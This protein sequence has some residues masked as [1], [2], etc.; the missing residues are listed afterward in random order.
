[1]VNNFSKHLIRKFSQVIQNKKTIVKLIILLTMLAFLMTGITIFG[2]RGGTRNLGWS[3]LAITEDTMFLG[4]TQG[5]MLALSIPGGNSIWE[6]T[7]ETEETTGGLFGCAAAAA[8]TPLYGTPIVDDDILYLGAYNGK[9][10]AFRVGKDDP[11][12]IFPR[13]GELANIVGGPVLFEG[14]IYIG[15]SDGYLY[16]LDAAEGYEEWKFLTGN[17][18]WA[19]P[20][21]VN[22][23]LYVGSFDHKLYAININ[24]HDVIWAP[25]ETEGAIVATPTVN[26]E[27]VYFGSFDRRIYALDITTGTLKWKSSLA[28]KWF[29]AQAIVTEEAVYAA[30][31]DGKVYVLDSE[32]GNDLVEAI[33]L[34]D[35]ISSSPVMIDD[36]IIIATESGTIWSIN[37]A[38]KQ[39]KLL[40]DLEEKI[41][42][43][44]AESNGIIYIHSQD[45]EWLYALNPRSGE[46][47]WSIPLTNED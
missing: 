15:V 24:T 35:P 13:Q 23:I 38:T 34:G 26:D 45:E 7:L 6:V 40:L 22:D 3:G 16:A 41:H 14:K 21:I 29:W 17:Q 30:C 39:Q 46:I 36:L 44:L 43:P 18:I 37:T 2:C 1:L 12:W 19:T 33:D 4:S 10:Y 32:N 28:E 25:Y 27:T 31:L 8:P 9:I 5:Q 11:K 42:A 47:L 20:A